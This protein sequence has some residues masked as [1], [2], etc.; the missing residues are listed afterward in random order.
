MSAAVSAPSSMTGPTSVLSL[1][2]S[3]TWSASIAAGEA[4]AELRVD[5]VLDDDPARRGALL[6]GVPHGGVRDGR[7]G[8]VQVG[9][10]QD[11]GRVLAAHLGLHPAAALG[12][13]SADLRPT[14]DEP[15]KEM[16]A[17]PGWSISAPAV[18]APP[19]TTWNTSGGR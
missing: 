15:V 5:R 9:V 14:S 3:S 2:G 10:G 11:D 1:A 12:R 6:A 19:S 8:P 17:T 18:V 16:A 13:P 7:G 4:V